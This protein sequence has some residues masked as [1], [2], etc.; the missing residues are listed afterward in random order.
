MA[1][2]G[3][4]LARREARLK[5]PELYCANLYEESY[6]CKHCSQ[7]ENDKLV[8]LVRRPWLYY[9]IVTFQAVLWHSSPI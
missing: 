7:D 8:K 1:H 6:K 5:E 4:R 9:H 3:K 2:I